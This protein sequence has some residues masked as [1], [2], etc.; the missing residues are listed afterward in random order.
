MEVP[1]CH[2]DTPNMGR[3]KIMFAFKF[4]SVF[5][6]L[7]YRSFSGSTVQDMSLVHSIASGVSQAG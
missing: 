6:Y 4:T 1:E 5:G 7:V 3:L 2:V